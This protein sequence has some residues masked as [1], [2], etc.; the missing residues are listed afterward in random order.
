MYQSCPYQRPVWVTWLLFLVA[1]MALGCSTA[2]KPAPGI[3]IVMS[4]R[5]QAFVDVQREIAKRYKERIQNYYL[6][7]NA[8]ITAVKKHV[9]AS[10]IS[11]VVAVGLPAAQM[12]REL[13]GKHVVFC[14]VFNYENPSLVT[15][16]M[17]GVA[18]TP[19]VDDL[20]RTWKQLSPRLN[21][22]G[23]ITGGNLRDLMEEAQTAAKKH[24]LNLIHVEARSDKETLYAFK[25]ISPKI[26]GLWMV[27]DNRVLS[28][29]V[30]RDIMAYSVRQG[31]QMAVFSDQLL[32]LGGLLS[33]ETSAAD[34]AEQILQRVRKI[35]KDSDVGVS[36]LTQTTIRINSVMAKRL[37]L[38]IPKSMRAMTHAP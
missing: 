38:K 37:N 32:A 26:E 8:D 31:D 9:Q 20:F 10:D 29:A 33:A 1:A 21:R 27:P 7:G 35:H 14:Q 16:W 5:S 22:V 30:I 2:P 36:G 15:P 25:R 23:V 18:A 12:A 11:V 4:D 19:P 17:K 24:G 3:A 6:D 34:I 28:R 13:S